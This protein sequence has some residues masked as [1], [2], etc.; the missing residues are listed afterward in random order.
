MLCISTSVPAPSLLFISPLNILNLFLHGQNVIDNSSVSE[1]FSQPIMVTNYN[2]NIS[3]SSVV[4]C[5]IY[6]LCKNIGFEMY[7]LP[8]T[9][10]V[11][12]I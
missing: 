3:C 7:A 10:F 8:K 4:L 6:H 12:V 2:V 9:Y 1:S 11:I 5:E